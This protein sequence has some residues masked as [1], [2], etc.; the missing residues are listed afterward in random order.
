MDA[1]RR[2]GATAA[3]AFCLKL[4]LDSPEGE[5]EAGKPVL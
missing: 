3:K 5:P 1:H 2:S 4:F